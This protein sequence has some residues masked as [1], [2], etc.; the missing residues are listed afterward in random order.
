MALW[1]RHLPSRLSCLHVDLSRSSYPV[2]R[3]PACGAKLRAAHVRGENH[4]P[5]YGHVVFMS[6]LIELLKRDTKK[7]ICWLAGWLYLCF[8]H[9]F[10]SLFFR[11]GR[12]RLLRPSQSGMTAAPKP[13][14]MTPV[15]PL[16]HVT[17]QTREKES[18]C[19]AGLGSK[20]PDGS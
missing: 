5:N 7:K 8:V 15:A 16:V 10:L 6:P 4:H 17:E 20:L 13:L 2:T 11:S 19:F 18:S 12:D 9:L 14:C 3:S 1:R